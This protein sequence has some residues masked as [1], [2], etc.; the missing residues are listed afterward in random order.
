METMS[1]QSK[2]LCFSFP[3]INIASMIF[4][5]IIFLTH[6]H[7]NW[8]INLLSMGQLTH[9]LIILDWTLQR[10]NIFFV[11]HG[12][13]SR[14]NLQQ[15]CYPLTQPINLFLALVKCTEFWKSRKMSR[16]KWSQNVIYFL[17]NNVIVKILISFYTIL[18][19]LVFETPSLK[20]Q[21][22]NTWF[23]I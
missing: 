9:R 20:T 23:L 6:H 10:Y 5:P 3:F 14:E 2:T 1:D 4:R 13:L 12:V 8:P 7:S 17:I 15:L 16:S 11:P 22:Y 18:L 21:G 19:L